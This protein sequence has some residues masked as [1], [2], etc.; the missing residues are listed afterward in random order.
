[1]VMV[2]LFIAL[3]YQVS[4]AHV[5]FQLRGEAADGDE[6]FVRKACEQA[7]IPF[8]VN[9]LD[10]ASYATEMGVS[11]QVAARELRYAWFAEI[12]KS[13]ELDKLATAHHLNDNL[14]T[15][16]LH[17]IRGT[18]I[19]GLAG[20]P[21]K[22]DRVIRPL[23][24]FKREEILSYAKE[25]E[26]EWREDASNQ[27][28]KYDRNFIRLTIL[29]LLKK[30]N[31]GLEDTFQKTNERVLGAEYLFQQRLLELKAQYVHEKNDTTTIDKTI[32]S[33][34]DYP[35][36][37]LWELV[38]KF[39]FNYDQLI[40]AVEASDKVSGKKFFSKSHKLI[41]D[42][43]SWIIGPLGDQ[44]GEMII[45]EGQLK[46]DLNDETMR[47]QWLTNEPIDGNPWKALL[48]A[49]ELQ[50]PLTWRKWRTGDFFYPLGMEHRKKVSDYLI[51]KKLSLIEKDKVTVLESNGDIVWLVGH[52][53]DNRYRI[54]PETTKVIQFEVIPH[55][56]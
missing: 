30:I 3:G 34:I 55:F 47:I 14:E 33:A 56:D 2:D 31:P 38:K 27:E 41:I 28:D 37:V 53:I 9:R 11:I 4:V 35:Q 12:M 6:T 43:G 20:I 45:M 15:S 19:T 10:A 1:M 46:A 16:L 32:I 42:R 13:N 49:T 23:L 21:Q 39:G 52:R 29:P 7:K 24:N 44:I 18:G 36:V 17:F 50:F 51:D 48:N 26:L 54:H 25:R 8:Y 22:T 40:D 5:N